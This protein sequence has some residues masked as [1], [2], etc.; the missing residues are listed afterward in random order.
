MWAGFKVKDYVTDRC[1]DTFDESL[2]GVVT[3]ELQDLLSGW[4]NAI[5]GNGHYYYYYYYYIIIVIIYLLLLFII[6]VII[7]I[8]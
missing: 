7:I 5:Y 3:E 8:Y 4:L 2:L 6:I 1:S